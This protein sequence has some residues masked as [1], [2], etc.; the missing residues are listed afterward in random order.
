[1]LWLLAAMALLFV[2]TPGQG[3]GTLTC[4]YVEAGP[5]GPAGNVLQI[6][7]KSNGVTHV[8][9]DGDAIVVF[10]NFDR[11]P[12][13]CA[14]TQATV[15]NV[16]R[17][18]LTTDSAPFINYLGDSALAPGASPEPSGPEIEIA[19]HESGRE[20]VLNVGGKGG[21]VGQ[22]GPGRVGVNL[23]PQADGSARDVDVVLPTAGATEVGVRLVGSS[24]SDRLTVL[25]GPEFTGPALLDG[26]L[27]AG[28]PGDD[29]LI[30]GPGRDR[31]NG[32]VGN[33]TMR[34]GR[35]DDRL[36]IG[37][38]RDRV[39]AG[40][41][42][43]EIFNVS[44]VGG[45]PE[46]TGPDRIDAGPGDDQVDAEQLLGGDRV[47]CGT[48]RHDSAFVDTDDRATGCER[49]ST[50]RPSASPAGHAR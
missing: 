1:M 9:R 33:D 43:D 34:A 49:T 2:A 44:D 3:R 5:P 16:D 29:T 30:G 46:D 15:F 38:G 31:L 27:L 35:G 8:Y 40:R 10:S 32:G 25:G 14:G 20:R 47:D 45:L 21:A 48:G 7:D 17:I 37:P 50:A 13:T 11:E 41:G 39:D 19:V 26:I 4:D 36:T 23:N 6:D 12:T 24:S 22:L 42:R 18:D 28:G